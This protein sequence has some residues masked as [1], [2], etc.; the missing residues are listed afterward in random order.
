MNAKESFDKLRSKK[1]GW[2]NLKTRL[3]FL[4]GAEVVVSVLIASVLSI[5]FSQWFSWYND[6]HD[7]IVLLLFS[8]FVAVVVTF[9][10]SKLFFDPIKKLRHAMQQVADGDFSTR[11]EDTS[12]SAEIREVY[13]GFNMMTKELSTTEILKSDFV[14]AVSHEFKT[15]LTAI[16]GYATLLQGCEDLT[17][18]GREYVEKILFN[19]KRL[20]ELT[21]NIL[22]LSKL[23]NQSIE[24]HKC[25]YRLDEQIRASVV[26]LEPRWGEK[27]IELDVELEDTWYYGSEAL[28]R[29][30]WDNL[31]GN[32]VKFGPEGS[33]VTV[34]LYAKGDRIC[35]YVDD[36]GQGITEEAQNH[37]F[38]KFY[39]ADS[40]H[41]QEGNGLGLSLVKQ[42]LTIVGGE[43]AV[44][45]LSEGGCRFT[46]WLDKIE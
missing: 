31:I 38:D 29:C 24:T 28:L 11:L 33:A 7:M 5:L 18:E 45:N 22:L 41:K 14:S 37:I 44:E 9:P 13:A 12:S 26:A 10:L 20:S 27:K 23:E 8:L 25:R 32:A 16:E 34:R 35:F 21:G 19:T 40:S 43:I 6:L 4:V 30:V 17:P 42:I 36:Q 2:F 46:V 3:V 1:I 39:Q 15:P